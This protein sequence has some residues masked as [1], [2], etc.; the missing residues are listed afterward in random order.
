MTTQ[1]GGTRKRN[2]RLDIA[3]PL[4]WATG[5]ISTTVVMLIV[6]AFLSVDSMAAIRAGGRQVP[7]Y[8]VINYNIGYEY[9]WNRR[10]DVPVIGQLE[11]LFGEMVTEEQAEALM[12][13]GKLVIQS[14]ACIACHTFYGNGAYYG[15]DLTKS[16]LDPAW[17]SIW[18][19][20]TGKANKEEAMAEFLMHPEKYPTWSRMMPN[21]ELTEKDARS[22]VAYLKWMSAVDTNGFP[23]N[24]G[25]TQTQR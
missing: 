9:D 6:L 3:E 18:I 20:M 5:A 14:R 17:D 8:S 16:W 15:P 22:V 23:A 25:Q 21:L 12:K 11:P 2:R 19:P 13:H 24:F 7:A 1:S 10:A 4:F